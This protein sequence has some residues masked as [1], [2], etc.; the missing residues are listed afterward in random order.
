ML[1]LYVQTRIDPQDFASFHEFYFLQFP[2]KVNVKGFTFG[3]RYQSTKDP[4][5]FVTLY[6]IENE[7][8]LE[9]LLSSHLEKRDVELQALAKTEQKFI[10]EE[11]NLGVYILKKENPPKTPFL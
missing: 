7:G 3:Y 4:M 5:N 11:V 2:K 6:G 10:L 9:K 1:L 8:Y